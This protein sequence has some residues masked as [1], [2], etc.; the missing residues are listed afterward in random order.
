M[1]IPPEE[2]DARRAALCE[3][4][5]GDGIVLLLGHDHAATTYPGNPYP[6]RQ[7]SSFRYCFGL[8]EPGAAGV[9]DCATGEATLYGHEPDLDSIIWEG[10]LPPLADRAAP[11]GTLRVAPTSQLPIDLAKV[12]EVHV[13]PATRGDVR[14]R[15]DSL[16]VRTRTDRLIPAMVQLREHKSPSELAEIAE[17]VDRAAVLHRM[18][19]ALTRPGQL[20]SA[21]VR[22][23]DAEVAARGWTPAYGTI[24]SVRGEVLHNPHHGN[25]MRAGDLVVHDGGVAS[26]AGY[27]SDITRTIPVSGR[28][29]PEQRALYEIVL[30]AHDAV[31]DAVRPGV[32]YRDMHEVA[33]RVITEGLSDFGWMR[34]DP[35]ESVAAGAFAAFLP[36]GV[37]HMLGLDV[38]DMEGIG[39]DHVGYGDEHV[40]SSRFG[41]ANLRLGKPVDEGFVMTVEPGIY[42]IPPLLERLSADP[43]IGPFIDA[44]TA[45]ASSAIGGIRIEDVVTVTERGAELLG[46][47]IPSSPDEVESLVG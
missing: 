14:L 2:F 29:T 10:D 19:F 3:A 23:M 1:P 41:I 13:V 15:M 4:L 6:F 20:E 33:G 31:I 18:A 36:H 11:F 22:A 26:D 45:L 46:A 30:A 24:F 44:E 27:A 7:E 42:R 21:V 43:A 17:A 39:E 34:G 25:E 38:H 40:R 16:G 8:D 9:L 32:P 37:G 5:D 28:F 47:P 35:D 12:D